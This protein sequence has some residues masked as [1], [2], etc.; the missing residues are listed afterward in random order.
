M[1]EIC[2]RSDPECTTG[3]EIWDNFNFQI[4]TPSFKYRTILLKKGV[5]VALR[6][7]LAPKSIISFNNNRLCIVYSKGDG[8]LTHYG[9]SSI[10]GH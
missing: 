3:Y 8:L 6:P 1:G 5:L 2:P 4:W 10:V 7:C 9:I